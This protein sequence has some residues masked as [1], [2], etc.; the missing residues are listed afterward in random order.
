M[1]QNSRRARPVFSK[2]GVSAHPIPFSVIKITLLNYADLSIDVAGWM[3]PVS[4]KFPSI[5]YK[6]K[7]ILTTLAKF[8]LPQG[9][10]MTKEMQVKG[11]MS[12]TNEDFKDSVEAFCSGSWLQDD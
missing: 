3:T 2:E 12:Y 5:D 9:D 4:T 11:S 8:V 7:E 10:F 1:L 6:Q